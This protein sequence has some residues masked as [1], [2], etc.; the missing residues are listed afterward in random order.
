VST[1]SIVMLA[2]VVL[3]ALWVLGAHN[4]L[5]RHR[6]AVVQTSGALHEQLMR[7]HRLVRGLVARAT[8]VA[9]GDSHVRVQAIVATQEAAGVAANHAKAAPVDPARMT[10][11]DRAEI[12]LSHRLGRFIASLA[13]APSCRDDEELR[14]M[15]QDIVRGAAQLEF[16]TQAFNHAVLAYNRASREAPTHI[17]AK[18]FG[19][20]EAAVV[21]PGIAKLPEKRRKTRGESGDVKA[22]QTMQPLEAVTPAL[23]ETSHAP[24]AGADDSSPRP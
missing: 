3:L 21:S 5:V 18:L 7:R 4:R 22:T 8:D 19:F 20:G 14:R 16:A 10:V 1:F 23:P 6:N 13:V 17:V 2:V 11:V 12:A 24:Q 15:R 9:V